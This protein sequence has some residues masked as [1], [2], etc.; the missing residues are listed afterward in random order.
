MITDVQ[1]VARRPFKDLDCGTVG[2][3][4]A[5][6]Y[7]TFEVI[8]VPGHSAPIAPHALRAAGG[9]SAQVANVIARNSRLRTAGAAAH[10]GAVGARVTVTGHSLGAALCTLFV[11]EHALKDA[12][13]TAL[14]LCNFASPRV[15]DQTFAERFNSLGLS[16]FNI[17]VSQDLVPQLPDEILGFKHVS[18]EHHLSSDGVVANIPLVCTHPLQT[19]LSLLDPSVSPPGGICRLFKFDALAQRVAA[20]PFAAPRAGGAA[21]GIPL[22]GWTLFVQRKREELRPGEGFRRT[23][24]TYQV[25]RDGAAVQGL[26]GTT[27]ERQGP[28]DNTKRGVLEHRCIEAGAYPLFT[29]ATDNYRTQGYETN[30]AH[31]RPCLLV[32]NTNKRTAILVHP[33]DGYGSTIGCI[34]L[35]RPLADADADI[36]LLDSLKRV[37]AVIE[38]LKDYSGGKFPDGEDEAPIDNALLI[39]REPDVSQDISLAPAAVKAAASRRLAMARATGIH[40]TASQRLVCDRI[41]NVFETDVIEGNY[42]DVTILHD[43]PGKI[44][45]ITYGAKQTTEYYN[46][47]QLIQM[48]VDA[49][50]I[51]SA[52]LAPY[53]PKIKVIP[54][55]DDQQFIKLLKDAG[56]K[57]QVMRQTQDAFFDKIYFQPA[58]AWAEANGFTLPLSMLVIFDSFIHSGQIRNDIRDDFPER[59]PSSGGDERTWISQYVDAR[60]N[61][62]ANH[63]NHELH[64]TVY[65]TQCFRREIQRDNWDLAKLPINAHGRLV[66][67]QPISHGGGAAPHAV[68]VERSYEEAAL[69]DD[70]VGIAARP[71]AAAALPTLAEIAAAILANPRITLAT[72]H[73]ETPLDDATP[74]Q[75]IADTAA[76]G[77]AHRS[78]I[79][80]A[81]G[82]TVVLDRRMLQGLLKLSE[83]FTLSVS[84]FCGGQHSANSRHYAGLG[85]DT[86]TINGQRVSESHPD[87]DAFKAQCEQLGATEVLGP[88]DPHH[89]SHVHAAWPRRMLGHN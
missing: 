4:F 88:G 62:L 36:S 85:F 50:G 78:K 56:G 9:L 48:Y 71:R 22:H 23:I 68:H 15:G 5:S 13:G 83:T 31:P 77:P 49:G 12:P 64:A 53:V 69:G 17:I 28:G 70:H 87:V 52:A 63:P 25:F 58:Q 14:S 55:V 30:G 35:S 65:R 44:R 79:G 47:R 89:D 32:G 41:I 54:L 45:Q 21:T 6:L 84:E 74:K 43:G 29:H 34:N 61:W 24:G 1:S 59:V 57:D 11:M 51:Y 20:E 16:S 82:G 75:N 40:L 72:A 76:G 81:P 26:T 60:E 37:I 19:Y 80:T 27:V 66:D 2:D 46:L 86:T 10:H 7:D 18:A 38:N 67:D 73:T 33:A 8:E 39:V 42:A 3:G